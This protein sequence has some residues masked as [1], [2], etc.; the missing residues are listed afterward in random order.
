MKLLSV[1]LFA[2]VSGLVVVSPVRAEEQVS[3][4]EDFPISLIPQFPNRELNNLKQNNISYS[5]ADLMAQGVTRV[6]GVEIIQTDE[7]L[8]LVLETVA[9]SE[10]LVPLIQP[11]GND[12]VIEILDATLAF[13]I[14]NGVTEINPAPGINRITVNEADNN[15]IRVRITG[16]SQT[17]S[18]EILP[19]RED[20][21]LSVTPDG[22]AAVNEPDDSINVIA[23]GQGE[24]DEY[25]VLGVW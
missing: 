20:L 3:G 8:E 6:T 25:F 16:D 10:R 21:V 22:T 24:E 19:G 11:E 1:L 7:G 17:P 14:R 12:L 18:A 23:T 5:A 9:G 15:S 13:A 2:S 4:G